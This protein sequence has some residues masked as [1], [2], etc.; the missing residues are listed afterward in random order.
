MACDSTGNFI[1]IGEDIAT[2]GDGY[3]YT[4]TN[5]G[6]SWTARSSAGSRAWVGMDCS[7][8]G[9]IIHACTYG[10]YIYTST[11][12]GTSWTIRTNSGIRNWITARCSSDGTIVYACVENGNIFRSSNSGST[13]TNLTTAGTGSWYGLACS[14]D[15]TKVAAI[16]RGGYIYISYDSGATWTTTGPQTAPVTTPTPTPTL[17]TPTPTPTPVSITPTITPTL[18][19]TPTRTPTPTVTAPLF[20]TGFTSLAYSSGVVYASN[21][22]GVK[23]STDNGSSWTLNSGSPS[24]S[25]D[26]G[27]TARNVYVAKGA[28]NTVILHS[29]WQSS[30]TGWTTNIWLSQNG[31]STF[32]RPTVASTFGRYWQP[33]T[34]TNGT[35]I[36]LSAGTEGN[37]A[38]SD[39]INYSTNSGSTWTQDTLPTAFADKG[40][41][42]MFTD[43]TA[44]NLVAFT[45]SGNIATSSNSASTW[46]VRTSLPSTNGNIGS[47]V[48]GDATPGMGTAYIFGSYE[49]LY[50]STN[51]GVSW[52][53]IGFGGLSTSGAAGYASKLICSDDGNTLYLI[54]YSSATAFSLF[55]STNGGTSWSEISSTSAYW[56]DIVCDSTG[57]TLF[58][59]RNTSTPN[60][61][62]T[63]L[64]KST[65]GGTSWTQIP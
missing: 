38:T 17:G 6:A 24:P 56:T 42:K 50:K 37:G 55:K 60:S 54:G 15:G 31:G 35:K 59:L 53:K 34:S 3:I 43:S 46:T 44:T 30:T 47:N 7:S 49:G 45:R 2:G 9:S 1:V 40:E 23:K 65:N 12:S 41:V 28:S 8:N 16:Q 61:G 19:I 10:N 36:I 64:W 48:I 14:S 4:T 39:Y 26:G 27:S 18:T 32:T 5:Q 11:D 33:V 52:T 57:S 62:S 20:G 22:Y 29:D 63:Q 21:Q 13:W 25:T 58:A 51:L